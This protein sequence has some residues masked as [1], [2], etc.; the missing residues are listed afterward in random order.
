MKY[1]LTICFLKCVRLKVNGSLTIFLLSKALFYFNSS[2]IKTC[3]LITKGCY[4]IVLASSQLI[5]CHCH[6][7]K[8]F[9]VEYLKRNVS[10]STTTTL[11]KICDLNL[12]CQICCVIPGKI[13][14]ALLFIKLLSSCFIVISFKTLHGF[15]FGII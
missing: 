2:F 1:R 9:G 12:F 11:S 6:E 8:T 13:Y 10:S 15:Q 4:L 3:W 14:V 7:L 5:M